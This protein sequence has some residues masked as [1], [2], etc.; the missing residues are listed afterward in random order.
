MSV[1][2]E[3]TIVRIRASKLNPK[4]ETNFIIANIR[5]P[6]GDE[7][8]IKGTVA[9][10]PE[11][12][13]YLRGNFTPEHHATYGAQLTSKG[14]ID[15]ELPRA[16]ATIRKRCREI[17]LKEGLKW[18]EYPSMGRLVDALTESNPTAFWNSF[19][20]YEPRGGSADLATLELKKLQE[21]VLAY[22]AHR[23]P[24]KSSVE[25]ERY[26]QELGLNWSS[27]AIRTMLGFDADG[28]EDTESMN[29]GEQMESIT[30]ERLKEDPLCIVELMDIKTAQVEQYLGALRKLEIIDE[31]TATIGT[32]LKECMNAESSGNCCLRLGGGQGVAAKVAAVRAHPT[33]P[34]Y[35]C[36]FNSSLYRLKIYRDEQTVAQLIVDAAR[37][38]SLPIWDSDEET[39]RKALDE[40]EPDRG[41]KANATQIAAVTAMLTRRIS[42]MQGSAGTGKTTA[43]RLLARYIKEHRE[44]VR[45]NCLFLAPTG[46][47]VNRIKESLRDIALTDADNIMTI[48]RFAGLIR[49]HSLG[50]AKDAGS[51]TEPCVSGPV[52]I[53]VDESSMISLET[54][55]LLVNALRLYYY[56]P[57]LVF[58]GDGTQLTPVGCGAPYLDLI[59]SKVAV[60]TTLTQVYRQ[61][62]DSALLTA[63]TQLRDASD[64][65]V[66]EP[67][68][69]EVAMVREVHKPMLRW[70]TA[71]PGGSIIVPTGKRGL[72][73]KLTPVVR[74][75]VNPPG[76][77]D[78]FVAGEIYPD[79]RK[80]D[81]VMQVKN[82]YSRNVFNGEVGVV[83]GLVERPDDDE[84]PF[85]LHVQF[86]GRPTEN[87]FY[88]L[89]EVDKEL[90]L[91]YVVTTHKSQGSEYDDVLVVMD[92]AIPYFINRNHIY[93]ATSR[94]KKSVKVLISDMEIMRLWKFKPE[95]PITGLVEQI[96]GLSV[97]VSATPSDPT[98]DPSASSDPSGT[99]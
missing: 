21:A 30:L 84:K 19:V 64:I 37:E 11:I 43:L 99:A 12:G 20:K 16:P 90:T 48:H 26:F 7:S 39:V 3:G 82:N 73:G 91:A 95:K 60:N 35:L 67:G 80:G 13:D 15:V 54:M 55:A 58:I 70:L 31:P 63:I 22:M 78:L 53:V 61:E 14:L 69:F 17:A 79:Y 98:T 42:T 56:I 50:G 2:L 87:F 76:P 32:L 74:D 41:N 59:A 5:D 92:Q 24:V 1:Q 49:A 83:C 86:E 10:R 68:L 45:G 66:S 51:L 97:P 46:K 47:A 94:G 72:V 9:R 44:D 85:L 18:T 65:T 4:Q 40:M 89:K 77:N 38:E 75:H 62:G 25:I 71:H 34:L 33:F 6:Y 23:K 8:T 36:E 88:S 27:T 81:K 57:H 52:L 96:G 93:T 28:S 29:P